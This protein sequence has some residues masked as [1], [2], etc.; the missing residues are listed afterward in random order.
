[1]NRQ[2]VFN[3]LL[4]NFINGLNKIEKN[5]DQE[6]AELAYCKELNSDIKSINLN[7]TL[8]N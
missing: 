2:I 8:K 7:K 4:K 1:M 5:Y 3:S 6:F